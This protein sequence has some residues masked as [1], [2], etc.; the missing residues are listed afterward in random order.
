M[1]ILAIIIPIVVETCSSKKEDENGYISEEEF[2]RMAN[3]KTDRIHYL[4]GALNLRNKTIEMKDQLIEAK[5]EV[6]IQYYEKWNQTVEYRKKQEK[7]FRE[8]EKTMKK[9]L[10]IKEEAIKMTNYALNTIVKVQIENKHYFEGILKEM[11]R[12][13][14]RQEMMLESQHETNERTIQI[15]DRV[16][17]VSEKMGDD[18]GRYG[19]NNAKLLNVIA[20]MTSDEQALMKTTT[21]LRKAI[22]KLHENQQI[23]II[24][25]I[26]QESERDETTKMVLSTMLDLIANDNLWKNIQNDS[27]IENVS[28]LDLMRVAVEKGMQIIAARNTSLAQEMKDNFDEAMKEI[29]PEIGWN[30]GQSVEEWIQEPAV[31]RKIIKDLRD[32]ALNEI[33]MINTTGLNEDE[34]R[35]TKLEIQ[36]IKDKIF[37]DNAEMKDIIAGNNNIEKMKLEVTRKIQENVDKAIQAG[38]DAKINQENI[39][40]YGQYEITETDIPR[41]A[42]LIDDPTKQIRYFT[43]YKHLYSLK[44]ITPF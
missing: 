22:A 10:A 3:E 30:D 6:A 25:M 1:I 13:N 17:T 18:I 4:E 32:K 21:G 31:K 43:K 38:I 35:E 44:S 14:D 11:M 2:N 5:E 16:I 41:A 8:T 15:L 9:E 19:E 33:K 40:L 34:L 20:N 26:E 36:L 39:T 7:F 24:K 23:Q 29:K 12:M 28:K 37:N 42:A 27:L